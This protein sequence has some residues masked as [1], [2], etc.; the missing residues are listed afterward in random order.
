VFEHASIPGTVTKHFLGSYAQR[1][2]REIAADT[3]LDLVSL[4]VMRQ[5]CPDFG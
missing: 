2:A 1:T 4:D 5:D 3:F